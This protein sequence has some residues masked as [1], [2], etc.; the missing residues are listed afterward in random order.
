MGGGENGRWR[1]GG[2]VKGAAPMLGAEAVASDIE[3]VVNWSN[4]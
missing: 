3:E 1:S 2:E 4:Q